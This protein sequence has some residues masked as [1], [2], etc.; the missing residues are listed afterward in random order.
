MIDLQLYRGQV[1]DTEGKKNNIGKI[2]VRIL[3][4]GKNW[5]TSLCPWAE[6]FFGTGNIDSIKY[7]SLSVDTYVWVFAS[8][9][10]KHVYYVGEWNVESFFSYSSIQDI[11]DSVTEFGEYNIGQIK[12]E[13]HKN[14]NLIYENLNNGDCGY[15]HKSGSY[16]IISSDGSIYVYSKTKPI[17]LYTNN[18]FIEIKSSG[19]VSINDN[20]TI[21][22]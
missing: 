22:C 6:P 12:F 11:I 10:F 5:K 19:Q 7:N 15:I 3:P 2:Q 13:L 14:G 17:K 8:K 21:D 1:T 16:S 20:L 4:E 18:G 9:G